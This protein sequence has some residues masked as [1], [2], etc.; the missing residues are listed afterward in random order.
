[1]VVNTFIQQYYIY[2]YANETVGFFYITS[3][4]DVWNISA[5]RIGVGYGKRNP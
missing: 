4:G 5:V 3:K 1:M 2:V